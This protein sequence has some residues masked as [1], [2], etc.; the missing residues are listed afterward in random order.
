MAHATLK[1]GYASLVDRLNRFPQ[2]APPVRGPVQD[3]RH[4]LQRARGRPRGAAADPALHRGPGGEGVGRAAKRRRGRPSTPSPD[5]P[6]SW[7]RKARTAS[8]TYFLPPP[9]AGFFEFSMMRVRSDIDQKTARELFYQYL[10]VEEDFIRALFTGETKLGRAFVQE[11][12]LPD[13]TRDG[14]LHGARLGAR[15]R[16]REDRDAPRRRRVLLPAQDGAPR[17]GLRRAE[18]ATA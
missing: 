11:A 3:P 1:S 18:G 17:P 15:E 4:A 14:T 2:G 5:G 12:A 16:G 13:L 7:T 8:R 9:M 10:N 6:S